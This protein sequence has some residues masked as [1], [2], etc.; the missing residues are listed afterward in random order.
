V[1]RGETSGDKNEKTG[2]ERMQEGEPLQPMV[3]SKHLGELNV[4]KNVKGEKPRMEKTVIIEKNAAKTVEK[5]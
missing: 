1:T 5:P 4:D 3:G 2:K